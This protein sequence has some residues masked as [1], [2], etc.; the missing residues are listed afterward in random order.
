MT[1]CMY[2]RLFCTFTVGYTGSVVLVKK[3]LMKI[4]GSKHLFLLKCKSFQ[5]SVNLFPPS[6]FYILYILKK[7]V[8]WVGL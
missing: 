8:S 7:N 1:F 2:S 4:L 6:N 3:S 5:S